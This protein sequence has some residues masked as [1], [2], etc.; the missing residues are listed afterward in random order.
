[1]WNPLLWMVIEYLVTAPFFAVLRI[2][3]LGHRYKELKKD[4]VWTAGILGVLMLVSAI[5]GLDGVVNMFPLMILIF[6]FWLMVQ[7]V[8][9]GE[10]RSKKGCRETGNSR[11]SFGC[12]NLF[13]V[14]G[15]HYSLCTAYPLLRGLYGVALRGSV[16]LSSLQEYYQF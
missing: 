4:Q 7:C 15:I 2:C 13:S 3:I 6:L 14:S 1:M 11:H 12:G 8:F 9:S 5:K 16:I 10:V